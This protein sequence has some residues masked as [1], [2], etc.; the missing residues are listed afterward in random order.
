MQGNLV[1][2]SAWLLRRAFEPPRQPASPVWKGGRWADQPRRSG[3]AA[4]LACP[5]SF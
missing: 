2:R 3:Q 1:R 5:T 4:P